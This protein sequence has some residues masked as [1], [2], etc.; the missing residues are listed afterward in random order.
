MPTITKAYAVRL[1][2]LDVNTNWRWYIE[3]RDYVYHAIMEEARHREP[4]HAN[5]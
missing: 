3:A 2:E 4:P 5:G 1:M